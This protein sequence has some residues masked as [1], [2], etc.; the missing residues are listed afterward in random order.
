[1]PTRRSFAHPTVVTVERNREID[2]SRRDDAMWT[3]REIDGVA[4]ALREVADALAEASS[5]AK[6]RDARRARDDDDDEDDGPALGAVRGATLA[7][8][9]AV[10]LREALERVE[11]HAGE[12]FRDV[13]GATKA[14]ARGKARGG[15]EGE[16]DDDDGEDDAFEDM[17]DK[18]GKPRRGSAPRRGH[19]LPGMSDAL[20]ELRGVLQKVG[21]KSAAAAA[22]AADD[23]T[24][25]GAEAD[26]EA[27][28]VESERRAVREPV[29]AAPPPAKAEKPQ[30]MVELAA[31]NAAKRA[32]QNS[33]DAR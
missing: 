27:S 3:T 1:M 30:W 12:A 33:S 5:E 13:E 17:F 23:P 19:T 11:A 18:D 22:E 2:A 29:V 24:S 28:E 31:K 32:A 6:S 4:R 16:G 20:G 26:G 10:K 14:A 9:C 8:N 7:G 25:S 21:V 15:E